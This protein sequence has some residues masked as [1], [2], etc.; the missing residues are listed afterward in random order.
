MPIL[1][2]HC[3]CFCFC[4]WRKFNSWPLNV[5]RLQNNTNRTIKSIA[6]VLRFTMKV[7]I[8]FM[9]IY[10][11]ETDSNPTK[12]LTP[13]Q[14]FRIIDFLVVVGLFLF[15]SIY[16]FFFCGKSFDRNFIFIFAA[17]LNL[18]PSDSEKNVW[19]LVFI[20][21]LQCSCL[22][23]VLILIAENF[24]LHMKW[25]LKF[26]LKWYFNRELIHENVCDETTMVVYSYM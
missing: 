17:Q 23:K 15:I 21:T 12:I 7:Y 2:H 3:C 4:W 11:V 25:F 19:C 16:L 24:L 22:S 26:F 20:I 10:S 9:E 6:K 18:W 13:L 14:N 1:F 5:L 8:L